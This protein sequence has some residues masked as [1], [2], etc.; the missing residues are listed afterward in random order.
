MKSDIR[1]YVCSFI[2]LSMLSIFLPIFK[3]I[4]LLKV[5]GG[6]VPIIV[7][8]TWQMLY[9]VTFLLPQIAA[10]FWLR[11]LAKKENTATLLW[12]LFG[13][14][15][16]IFAVGLFYL[17]QINNRLEALHFKENKDNNQIN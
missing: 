3:D 12:T 8:A 16:G 11:Y 10:A 7:K 13:L 15:G 2:A 5:Y 14:V 17:M 1:P 4:Y 6:D 9:G